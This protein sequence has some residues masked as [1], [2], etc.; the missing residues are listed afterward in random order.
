MWMS[1]AMHV[2]YLRI[3]NNKIVGISRRTLWFCNRVYEN[4]WDNEYLRKNVNR[5]EYGNIYS[6]DCQCKQN[7]L[8][9]VFLIVV[10]MCNLFHKVDH[11][12]R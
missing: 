4:I 3:E 1:R 9:F 12:Y 8:S 7:K 5:H 2:C 6:D 10:D 11:W